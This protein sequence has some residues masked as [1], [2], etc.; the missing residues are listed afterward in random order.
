M[1]FVQVCGVKVEV[2]FLGE[3]RDSA[4]PRDAAHQCRVGLQHV[5]ASVGDEIAELVQL[6]CHL[7]G[8]DPDIGGLAQGAHARAVAAVQRLL[9][10]VHAEALEL[11]RD[12]RASFSD[13]GVCVSQGMRQP[14][15]QS[16]IN[17]SFSRRGREPLPAP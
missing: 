15:L 3:S 17:S 11:A 4:Q 8:R 7:A 10:P 6:P 13:Q 9:H 5:D 1:P 12:L 14:W 2:V 16:T